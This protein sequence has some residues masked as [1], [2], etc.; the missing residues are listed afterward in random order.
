VA[1][2]V[3]EVVGARLFIR[4][5]REPGK[6]LFMYVNSKRVQAVEKHVNSQIVFKIFNSVG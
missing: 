6:T 5:S 2:D 1:I 4:F 3:I